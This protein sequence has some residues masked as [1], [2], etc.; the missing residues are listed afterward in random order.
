MNGDWHQ[1]EAV[2][3]ATGPVLLDFDGPVCGVYAGG[4]NLRASGQLRDQLHGAG[5][6][7]PPELQQERDPLAVLQYAGRLNNRGLA[8]ALERT[9]TA[10]EV[11]GVKTAP[12]T[13][14]SDDF[15][16]AC[17]ETH[18]PVVVVSNNAAEA[19]H[20]YLDLHDLGDFVRAVIGRP[21]GHPE[22]MKP[23]PALVQ[24]A[25]NELDEPPHRC[26]LIGDSTTDIEVGHTTGLRSIAYVKSPNRRPTLEAAQ[27]D[28]LVDNM[29]DLASAARAAGQ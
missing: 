22:R 12:P 11:E 26:V 3:A 20:T 1:V 18:R 17:H 24:A 21:H 13:G 14:G 8:E 16:Y 23:D 4:L 6:D 10:L 28:A 5:V 25:L 15:L 29:A 27:P 9:L 2:L 19:I 7:I